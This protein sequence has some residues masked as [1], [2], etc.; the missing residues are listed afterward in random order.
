M[1]GSSS[2]SLKSL[3]VGVVVGVDVAGV[4]GT[5]SLGREHLEEVVD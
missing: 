3:L 4:L 2:E 1:E 5:P